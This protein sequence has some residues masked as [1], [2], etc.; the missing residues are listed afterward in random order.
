ML[1]QPKQQLHHI[2]GHGGIQSSRWFVHKKKLFVCSGCVFFG[3]S[4]TKSEEQDLERHKEERNWQE[5]TQVPNSDSR[6]SVTNC[7]PTERR[8]FSPPDIP[9]WMSSPT[10]DLQTLRRLS[11][12]KMRST[13]NPQTIHHTSKFNSLT[14]TLD[15]EHW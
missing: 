14:H 5:K 15:R 10:L 8:L 2:V 11:S 3:R 4:N 13:Y 7:T 6:G 9:R 12:L 1:G